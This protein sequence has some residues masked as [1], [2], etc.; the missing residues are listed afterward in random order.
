MVR[1]L[2]V[3]IERSGNGLLRFQYALDADISRI[4]VPERRKSGLANEL[5]KHTCFEAFVARAGG[6][7]DAP[8]GG[9]SELNFSPSTEWAAYSF[10]G[11][12]ESMAPLAMPSPPDIRTEV[13]PSRLRVDAR[14]DARGLFAGARLRIALA[15]VIEDE[16]GNF[17]YW[18][19]KHAPAKPDF[20]HPSG[21]IFEV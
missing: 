2:E 10:S 1:S 20:H 21:F 11:Y 16:S 19:L 9:Y 3:Q 14:V 7:V 12:R 4:R 15:A 8:G 5:W 17:S 13:T 18:A 6:T